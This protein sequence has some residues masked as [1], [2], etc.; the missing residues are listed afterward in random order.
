M[1]QNFEET[2]KNLR[3]LIVNVDELSFKNWSKQVDDLIQD[4]ITLLHS[5]FL[6]VQ[7]SKQGSP[8]NSALAP[9]GLDLAFGKAVAKKVLR[10]KTTLSSSLFHV[11]YCVVKE[12]DQRSSINEIIPRNIYE[13]SG[14]PIS[15]ERTI[16]VHFSL[17]LLRRR[18]YMKFL[19]I[20]AP[21][22]M[23]LR[24][25][26]IVSRDSLLFQACRNLDMRAIR[27]L[28]NSCMASPY[29]RM[30]DDTSPVQETLHSII[31]SNSDAVIRKGVELLEFLIRQDAGSADRVIPAATTTTFLIV[32]S[33]KRCSQAILTDCLR[34]ILRYS[35]ENPLD[36]TGASGFITIANEHEPFFEL[37]ASEQYWP[38]HW[39]HVPFEEVGVALGETDRMLLLDPEGYW[40][41]LEVLLGH[42]YLALMPH[43]Y[44][45]EQSVGHDISPLH[46]LLLQ[47]SRSNLD[48]V[49][50]ACKIRLLKLICLNLNL[51]ERSW[52]PDAPG[53]V[54]RES[55]VSPTEYARQ[56]GV[57]DLWKG[58]LEDAGWH[59]S[60]ILNLV[61]EELY[62]G[63]SE[64]CS[65]AR[66]YKTRDDCRKEFV[67]NL[68]AGNF[69]G[70]HGEDL[71]QECRVLKNILDVSGL[72]AIFNTIRD[73]NIAY[74]KM[75]SPLV[76]GGWLTYEDRQ[77]V[78]GVDF[79]LPEWN[80]AGEMI[81]WTPYLNESRQGIISISHLEIED[82]A[83]DNDVGLRWYDT[84]KF[85]LEDET[86]DF[87]YYETRNFLS[88]DFYHM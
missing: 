7:D 78:P 64:L 30:D 62:A 3:T 20:G 9:A 40:M 15:P 43:F 71:V 59:H 14:R 10:S 54:N 74:Q 72:W 41:E 85:W 46:S 4:Q 22:S 6:D 21:I 58:A 16:A 84:N 70:M 55:R 81:D 18:V 32:S 53:T 23:S 24:T 86:E 57:L 76:P 33:N 45:M 44:I 39:G 8:L 37:L 12:D 5:K 19:M 68:Y 47:A 50:K 88:T 65:G 61:D 63:I 25:Y 69:T 83:E 42:R 35:N 80:G 29:D 26:N 66:V 77:I 38:I 67:E 51:E 52:S 48:E 56:L 13:A 73:A 75:N 1:H 11:E 60:D 27:I 82:N 28:F 17:P 36:D 79:Q 49:I 87:L 2:G 34:L 31:L